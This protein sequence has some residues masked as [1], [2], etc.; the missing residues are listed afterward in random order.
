M[1]LNVPSM[2]P[3]SASPVSRSFPPRSRKC[4]E[5]R[6]VAPY[7]LAVSRVPLST[8]RALNGRMRGNQEVVEALAFVNEREPLAHD[9][10]TAGSLPYD[11]W[12]RLPEVGCRYLQFSH[13]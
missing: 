8:S 7:P 4:I 10:M 12:N 13:A 9:R 3:A 6:K 5:R 11:A 1:P 2:A